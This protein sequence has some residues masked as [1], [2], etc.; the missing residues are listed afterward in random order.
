MA[1]RGEYE[2][3]S[4][5]HYVMCPWHNW[6]FDV[7]TGESFV[8]PRANRLR[9]YE[10]YTQ[11]GRSLPEGE[12]DEAGRVG[13]PYQAETFPTEVEDE[14]LVVVMPNRRGDPGDGPEPRLGRATGAR[15]PEG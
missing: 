15:A 13:G 9:A 14:Y 12:I 10:V 7:D 4:G 11:A 1:P 8:D 3:V 6:E 5:K 2:F